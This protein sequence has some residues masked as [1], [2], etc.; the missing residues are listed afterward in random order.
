MYNHEETEENRRQIME[1]SKENTPEVSSNE[2][3]PEKTPE[4]IT[5]ESPRSET[6]SETNEN[7]SDENQNENLDINTPLLPPEIENSDIE[8]TTSTTSTNSNVTLE[9]LF[10]NLYPNMN[11]NEFRQVMAQLYGAAPGQEGVPRNIGALMDQQTDAINNLVAA[12]NNRSHGKIVEPPIFYGRD[13]EDPHRWLELFDQAFTTNGWQ[14]GNNQTRKIQIAAGYLRDAAFDWY[15]QDQGNITRYEDN[16]HNNGNNNFT[17]Q[18]LAQYST[19]TK[20]NLWTQQLTQMKQSPTETVDGYARRFRSTLTKATHGHQLDDVYQVGHF[21][22]G[23]KVN[24]KALT[25]MD[26]PE[27][28]R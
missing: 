27:I 12:Q 21:I 18:F 4:I 2:I 20:R 24:L 11:Q 8:S 15:R 26:N 25:L 16:G 9:I 19:P 14:P 13:D 3:S 28:G 6:L 5:P 7:Q 17:T 10:E 1:L 23:L 22:N